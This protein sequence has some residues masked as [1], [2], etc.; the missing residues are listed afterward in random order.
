M[1]RRIKSPPR[2]PYL[3]ASAL[4]SNLECVGAAKGAAH[5]MIVDEWTEG[6]PGVQHTGPRIELV[7]GD[8]THADCDAIV[9]SICPNLGGGGQ[10]YS[11]VARRGGPIIESQLHRIHEERFPN[12]LPIGGCV[13]TSG[14]RLGCP[15]VVHAAG[16]V[17]SAAP[18]AR[19]ELATTYYNALL[20]AADLG[21]TRVAVPAI[22]V[23][24]CRFPVAEAAAIAMNA[25][26]T[27]G[28]PLAVV[29]FVLSNR[30]VYATFMH[31]FVADIQK[32]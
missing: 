6:G 23:G 8:I 28:A 29:R 7:L 9:S 16:P 3:C 11:T 24:A 13:A 15:W 30:L 4:A 32:R 25:V 1:H 20:V 14:G 19:S 27:T 18:R 17:W 31:A 5:V 2:R 10:L 21:A 22:S 12:G 26:R